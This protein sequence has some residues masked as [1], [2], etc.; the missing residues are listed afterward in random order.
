[1][2]LLRPTFTVFQS[3]SSVWRTT[4][5]AFPQTAQVRFQ[6]TSSMWRTTRKCSTT[7]RTEK[8]FQSTSSVWRTT[9]LYPD[10]TSYDCIS[11]HVLRVEDDSRCF[12][13]VNRIL[14][15]N[16]RPPC[17]GRRLSPRP[18][19]TRALFQSPSSVWRTTS[20]SAAIVLLARISIPVLRVEDDLGYP[21]GSQQRKDFN[22]RPPC[23]GRRHY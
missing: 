12:A 10:S 15:F 20:P 11:I 22:P 3:T 2:R 21:G 6:S 23:G 18:F 19:L 1:M 7:L 8:I 9:T 4:W 5:N 14:N 16:P 17:G 13:L